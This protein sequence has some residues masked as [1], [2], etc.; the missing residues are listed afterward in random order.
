MFAIQPQTIDLD[1]V[2][3]H[4]T[5]DGEDVSK[6]LL[7]IEDHVFRFHRH[8]QL[9]EHTHVDP[10]LEP[11]LAE[12]EREQKE[13]AA[14]GERELKTADDTTAD[15]LSTDAPPFLG[16]SGDHEQADDPRLPPLEPQHE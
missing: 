5:N 4:F 15:D 14:Q 7:I 13:A 10:P 8:G 11:D 12:R 9:I 3:M 6:C 1:G 16:S 2:V